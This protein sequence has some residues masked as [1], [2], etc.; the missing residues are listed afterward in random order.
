MAE[1]DARDREW[2]E[3]RREYFENYEDASPSMDELGGADWN[4]GSMLEL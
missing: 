1:E 4:D 2:R 3:G